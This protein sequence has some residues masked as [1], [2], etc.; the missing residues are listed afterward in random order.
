M[1]RIV[2]TWKEKLCNNPTDFILERKVS[3]SL[4]FSKPIIFKT[5]NSRNPYFR[6]GL[7]PVNRFTSCSETQLLA[8][9]VLES[10]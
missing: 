4:F 5:Y 2:I 9:F 6:M 1:F 3:V 10:C 7:H 8:T